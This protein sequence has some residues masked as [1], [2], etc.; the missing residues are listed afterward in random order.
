MRRAGGVNKLVPVWVVLCG[1]A[2]SGLALAFDPADPPPI[3]VVGPRG[4]SVLAGSGAYPDAVPQFHNGATL[5]CAGCHIS[6]ASQS[7]LF[8]PADPQP[9]EIVPWDQEPNPRL[10]RAADPLDLCLSCHDD[11]AFAPDVVEAD[12]G[13]AELNSAGYFGL[14]EVTNLNGHDLGR[15]LPEGGGF[16]LCMRCHFSTGS[17]QK[18][19]CI[20]CHNPH[21]N[22]IARNLQ[23]ASD[24]GG[25]PDL[26][27]F[28]NPVAT[29]LERYL[30]RNV[31]YGTLG[32][33]ALREP[34]NICL[35]CHHIFS[36]ATYT[37]PDANGF[38]NRH[39]TYDSER[40]DPNSIDQGGPDG[41]T[42]P[43][44]WEDG[45]GYG[46]V[47]TARLRPVVAGATSFAQGQVVDAATNGVFCLSCHRAHGS[48]QPFSL[49]WPVNDEDVPSACWQCHV[50]SE[51]GSPNP[52]P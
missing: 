19:T 30:T 23:W 12:P 47:G 16:G 40:G 21:G 25:T 13:P 6:H 43:G 42:D 24:P 2:V 44:H 45:T 41:T 49:N 31:S 48:N 50:V 52:L 37:D 17:E 8:D 34:T 3:H 36:G 26:G 9:G 15:N 7:H 10:L 32:S 22:N 28:T 5:N 29:G 46:F 18:V 11:K 35:D 27:L 4:S 20:D 33:S 51:T 14:P 38:H 39:P 1:L